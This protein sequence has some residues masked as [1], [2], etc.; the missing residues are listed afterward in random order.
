MDTKLDEI[1]IIVKEL[2]NEV[3]EIQQLKKTVETM[4]EE[5]VNIR[6]DVNKT[7]AET[8]EKV[9]LDVIST[10]RKEMCSLGQTLPTTGTRSHE[11]G[12]K[13][14]Y[15]DAMETKKESIIIV[16]PKEKSDACSS[17]QTS[18]AALMSLN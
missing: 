15:S 2:K 1:L 5:M 7:I 4:K 9:K 6:Q 13:K 14:S 8:V 3:G 18:R 12:K 10:I 16:K 17:D 11:A